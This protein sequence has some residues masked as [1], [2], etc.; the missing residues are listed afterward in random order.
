MPNLLDTTT[1][2]IVFDLYYAKCIPDGNILIKIRHNWLKA[3]DIGIYFARGSDD[4]R[5][6]FGVIVVK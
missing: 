4:Q 3:R 2:I 5:M 1:K 6:V